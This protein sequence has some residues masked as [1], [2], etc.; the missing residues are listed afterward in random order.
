VLRKT[1][2]TEKKRASPEPSEP[3]HVKAISENDEV[4]ASMLERV[5]VGAVGRDRIKWLITV[6]AYLRADSV[7]TPTSTSTET[8]IL[9]CSLSYAE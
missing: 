7:S 9:F 2:Y 4:W 5:S 1:I 8:S 6:L 3:Q